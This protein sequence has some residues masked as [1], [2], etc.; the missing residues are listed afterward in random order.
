MEGNSTAES[1]ALKKTNLMTVREVAQELR[2]GESTAYR[3]V[4]QGVI[5]A[6]RIGGTIRVRRQDLQ[7]AK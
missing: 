5:P 3:Y 6:I 2:V 4:A 1:T 7:G